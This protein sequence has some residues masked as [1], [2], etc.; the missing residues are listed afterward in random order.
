MTNSKRNME[1]PPNR[2]SEGRAALLP[3]RTWLVAL[4]LLLSCQ[5][6]AAVFSSSCFG[7][8]SASLSCCLFP[9]LVISCLLFVCLLMCVSLL[10]GC[11]LLCSWQSFPDS[12]GPTGLLPYKS[13]AKYQLASFLPLALCECEPTKAILI[14]ANRENWGCR[15]L[16]TPFQTGRGLPP[17]APAMRLCQSK[18]IGCGGFTSKRSAYTNIAAAYGCSSTDVSRML[19]NPQQQVTQ[20]QN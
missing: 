2:D 3:L 10:G 1:P 15:S 6:K 4:P 16:R 20:N 18:I 17:T 14:P 5:L 19:P 7:Q 13:N 11:L 12:T 9:A 8:T